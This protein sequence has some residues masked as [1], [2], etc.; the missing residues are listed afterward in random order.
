MPCLY[1]ISLTSLVRSITVI[2]FRLRKE[3]MIRFSENFQTNN[4]N[5]KF[6]F[7]ILLYSTVYFFIRRVCWMYINGYRFLLLVITILEGTFLCDANDLITIFI[8]LECFK[9]FNL[10]SYLLYG[11]IKKNIQ[12]NE[13]TT[14][15]LVIGGQTLLFWFMVSLAYMVSPQRD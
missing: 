9:C 5:K 15:Y 2:L 1:F 4:L 13:T 6:Q 8:V 3:P 12:T 14:K 10:Y 11:Y 7:L